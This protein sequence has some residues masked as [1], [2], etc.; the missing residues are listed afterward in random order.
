MA[1]ENVNKSKSGKKIK[2]VKGENKITNKTPLTKEE[3]EKI[4]ESEVG[5]VVKER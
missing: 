4:R 5:R 2:K 3:I 1:K